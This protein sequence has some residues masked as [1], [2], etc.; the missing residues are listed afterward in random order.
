MPARLWG[1]AARGAAYDYESDAIMKDAKLLRQTVSSIFDDTYTLLSDNDLSPDQIRLLDIIR[2][3][4]GRVNLTLDAI[5]AAQEKA[6]TI[7]ALGII[8]FDYVQP[9]T[10]IKA[11]AELLVMGAGGQLN[12]R[13][14]PYAQRILENILILKEWSKDY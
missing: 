1:G 10:P 13:Q 14:L 12:D 11:Y 5:I 2:E 8:L 3:G 4:V 6:D 7:G 9:L